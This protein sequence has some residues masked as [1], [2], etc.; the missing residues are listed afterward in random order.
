MDD[1]I[2]HRPA[3]TI[4]RGSDYQFRQLFLYYVLYKCEWIARLMIRVRVALC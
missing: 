2:P 3:T 4:G 1:E